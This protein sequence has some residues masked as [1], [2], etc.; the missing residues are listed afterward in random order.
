[1]TLSSAYIQAVFQAAT[2]VLDFD[3]SK[4]KPE[5]LPQLLSSLPHH[6]RNLET[7]YCVE[8]KC[9]TPSYP[10]QAYQTIRVL[11][12]LSSL[13]PRLK[14]VVLHVKLH[15]ECQECRT[16]VQAAGRA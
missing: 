14:S 13:F 2:V 5:G 3:N 6:V 4:V 1:M 7:Q 12:S 9:R 15:H 8:L 16:T 10:R 11:Q